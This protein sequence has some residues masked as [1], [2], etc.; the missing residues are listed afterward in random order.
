MRVEIPNIAYTTI[1]APISGTV[2]SL[3]V[4]QGQTINASQS[5]PTVLRIANLGTMTVQSDVSEADVA[6]LHTG[7]PVYF[8]T[9]SGDRQ[10][11]SVL[12]RTDPTPKTQNSV[13]LYNALFDIANEGDALKPSMT[14]QVFF[15]NA[16]S[17]NVLTV[18]MAAL[19]QGQ[20]IAREL[21]AK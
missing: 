20:Q 9:L 15:V 8:T 7:M 17:E 18:P 1:T 13:V 2:M 3:A 12:K 19:Q 16:S 11:H 6:K 5:A 14:A 4:K 10:R 21:A